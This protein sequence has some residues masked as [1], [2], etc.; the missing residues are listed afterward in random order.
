[1]PE[2]HMTTKIEFYINDLNGL[3]TSTCRYPLIFCRSAAK[4]TAI[5]LLPSCWPEQ[6]EG[7]WEGC[8]K[9]VGWAMLDWVPYPETTNSTLRAPLHFVA[10]KAGE[11]GKEATRPPATVLPHPGQ[12][13]PVGS[14][15]V[16]PW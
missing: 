5:Y 13:T 15:R 7:H 14:R 8:R 6:S 9:V 12:P 10:Q 1:M 3:R 4:S 2:G 16:Q 11:K